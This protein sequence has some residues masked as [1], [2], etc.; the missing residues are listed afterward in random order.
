MFDREE[1]WNWGL[2]QEESDNN[3]TQQLVGNDNEN[4]HELDGQKSMQTIGEIETRIVNKHPTRHAG[5]FTDFVDSDS[6]DS[7]NSSLDDS[8][9]SEPY[10]YWTKRMSY[11][12]S[13]FS[14][15]SGFSFEDSDD[16]QVSTSSIDNP[17]D[18]KIVPVST[19]P[20]NSPKTTIS[21]CSDLGPSVKCGW[22]AVTQET[23]TFQGPTSI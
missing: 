1:D 7:D 18:E 6:S 9:S 15:C 13:P 17:K 19:I 2:V 8:D 20:P 14:N 22:T 12:H 11:T 16:D 5:D 21:R 4:I 3:A 10:E 23:A